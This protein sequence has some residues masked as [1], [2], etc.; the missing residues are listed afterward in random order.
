MT[1][2]W[3]R[4]WK[5]TID[6]G[7]SLIDAS[8]FRIRFEVHQDRLQTPN[9]CEVIITNLSEQTAQKIRKEGQRLSLSAGYVGSTAIVFEGEIIQKRLGRE[10]VT[11][12]YVTL[13]ARS[14]DRAYNNATVNK[15]L[16][17]GH[18]FR[19]QVNVALDA[20]KPFG[21]TAGNI[22]DLGATKM[23]RGAALFGMARDLLRDIGF[24]TKTSWYI[25]DQK[26]NI[27]KDD[28]ADRG[29]AIVLNS[30][31]GLIWRPVQT[32]DGIIGKCLIS[33]K[34]RPGVIVKIDE[35]SIDQAAFDPS[36]LGDVSNSMIPSTATD[37]FYKVLSVDLLGDTR[38]QPWYCE[39]IC[40]R[41]DGQGPLPIG[42]VNKGVTLD[43]APPATNSSSGGR[44]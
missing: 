27:T 22:A 13:L 17:A 9:W 35:K 16:A 10:T 29:G 23:P 44:I 5:L 18:T 28:E 20:M 24:A 33:P 43:P 37:G 3:I 42:L 34:V 30:S 15:T 1:R 14:G 25:Q 32:F 26:L 6:T 40:I 4:D 11:D 39:F 2:Q 7:Q 36:Y 21:I 19:D 41:A 38:G 31:T 8:D 12:T